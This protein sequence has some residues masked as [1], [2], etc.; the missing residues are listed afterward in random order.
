M[1]IAIIDYYP[2]EESLRKPMCLQNDVGEIKN[3]SDVDA[4]KRVQGTHPLAKFAWWA[5][6]VDDGV[7]IDLG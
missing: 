6:N 1:W 3:F 5:F 7:V 2:P 4:I